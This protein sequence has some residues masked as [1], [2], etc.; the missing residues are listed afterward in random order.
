MKK[1][2][3]LAL[4]LVCSACILS[5][6]DKDDVQKDMAADEQKSF[7]E[8]VIVEFTKRV[9][10]SDF[11]EL[12][13]FGEDVAYIFNDYS[14]T[15]VGDSL[16]SDYLD[17]ILTVNDQY[18]DSV[19]KPGEFIYGYEKTTLMTILLSNFTGHF[20][21]QDK[22][23][24]YSEAKDLAFEFPDVNKKNC[25]LKIAHEGKVTE[26]MLPEIEDEETNSY[27]NETHYYH[28]STEIM[29]GIPEKV[30]ISMSR[31]GKDVV[32]ATISP[33][34][35]NLTE[36]KFIDIGVTNMI[37]G[38]EFVLNN[39]YKC[40]YR[41][42]ESANEKLAIDFK[43]SN[44]TGELISYTLSG[45]PSGIPSFILDEFSDLYVMSDTMRNAEGLNTRNIYM[46]I[47]V[48][49]K[50]QMIGRVADYMQFV[51]YKYLL[52]YYSEKEEEFKKT[53]ADL[54]KIIEIG[55][56]YN[57]SKEKQAYM[58]LEAQL[59]TEN[60]GDETEEWW[61]VIPVMVFSDGARI[62]CEEFFDKKGFAKAIE[63]LEALQAQYDALF[64]D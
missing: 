14:W 9:P 28:E 41:F 53:V 20:K 31:D 6:N 4:T 40:S 24:V 51:M 21:A 49:G 43:S 58:E 29:V 32:K 54:N 38:V 25:V 45:D 16:M 30:I 52:D 17:C 55:L 59:R 13:A 64:N 19:S 10:A 27:Q 12:K 50:A 42:E 35:N 48:L 57:G 36:N 1:I 3:C 39:G 33:N 22:G 5:C 2:K 37:D 11:E 26:F 46:S 44:S 63:A 18:V 47:S 62:S 23:W 34:L 56:Y 60:Y 8:N 15:T 7:L 61:E